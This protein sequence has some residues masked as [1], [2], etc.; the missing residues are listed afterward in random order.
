MKT[1]SPTLPTRPAPGSGS[2]TPRH[3][4]TGGVPSNKQ[5]GTLRYPIPEDGRRPTKT[6][7]KVQTWLRVP[8]LARVAPLLD[9]R[10]T[11]RLA[12]HPTP[13]PPASS[14]EHQPPFCLQ[15]GG[16]A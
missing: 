12:R 14:P 13:H 16:P 6:R 15:A 8:V 10:P 2:Q 9:T 1:V 4:H 7:S 3:G 5:Q 11:P